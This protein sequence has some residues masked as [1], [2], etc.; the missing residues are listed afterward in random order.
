MLG[1]VTACHLNHCTVF[2]KARED[3]I[4]IAL[5]SKIEILY[6][7]RLDGALVKT[8]SWKSNALESANFATIFNQTVYVIDPDGF[9]DE[10]NLTVIQMYPVTFVKTV[11][12][13]REVF[14]VNE[15]DV[16]GAF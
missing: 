8:I 1:Q 15:D 6:V 14:C 16:R 7:V 10:R 12:K 9:Y 4:D 11:N 5:G 2:G 3:N 13:L